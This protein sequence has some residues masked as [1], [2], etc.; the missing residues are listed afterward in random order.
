MLNY[1]LNESKNEKC[2]YLFKEFFIELYLIYHQYGSF[3][4]SINHLDNSSFI[5]FNGKRNTTFYKF[6]FIVIICVMCA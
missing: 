2:V 1:Y 6:E 3:L 4:L 5:Y